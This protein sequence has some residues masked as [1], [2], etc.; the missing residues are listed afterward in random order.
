MF[1]NWQAP[2]PQI[3]PL[4]GTRPNAVI[5]RP[6]GQ[7]DTSSY[8]TRAQAAL[9]AYDDLLNRISSVGDAATRNDLLTWISRSDVPGTPA[10]RRKTVGEDLASLG[11]NSDLST[12]QK[13]VDDLQAMNKILEAKVKNAE[14]AFP[15]IQNPKEAGQVKVSGIF[16]PTGIALGAVSILSLLVVP[17]MVSGDK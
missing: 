12:I 16:T 5:L 4:A 9:A 3:V 10:E 8:V 15:P 2:R 7:T 6:M 14:A 1:S 13:R 17:L 11:P